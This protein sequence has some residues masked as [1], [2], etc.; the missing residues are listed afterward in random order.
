[1]GLIL[2]G[3]FFGVQRW[4]KHGGRKDETLHTGA[5]L[6]RARSGMVVSRRPFDLGGVPSDA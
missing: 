4:P 1:M 6:L 2:P 3:P 5:R